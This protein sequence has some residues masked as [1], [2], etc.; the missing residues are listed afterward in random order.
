MRL[1]RWSGNKARR[2]LSVEKVAGE[3]RSEQRFFERVVRHPNWPCG[4]GVQPVHQTG[5]YCWSTSFKVLGVLF[6]GEISSA[7]LPSKKAGWAHQFRSW[8]VG[9]QYPG[10]FR[11]SHLATTTSYRHPVSGDNLRLVY[12]VDATHC[13]SVRTPCLRGR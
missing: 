2:G 12:G 13:C 10:V 11:Q 5:G 7:F 9:Q 8:V 4:E 6:L 3:D 1:R